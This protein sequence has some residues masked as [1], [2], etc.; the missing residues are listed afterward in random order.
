MKT[1]L[2]ALLVAL[3]LLVMTWKAT[4]STSHALSAANAH[5]LT[6]GRAE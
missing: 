3:L 6:N 2:N 1:N 4:V 5:P